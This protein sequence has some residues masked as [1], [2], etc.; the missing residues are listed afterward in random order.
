MSCPQPLL[1]FLFLSHF[2]LSAKAFTIIPHEPTTGLRL[3][4]MFIS[5]SNANDSESMEAIRSLVDF[6]DGSWKGKGTSFSV[7]ADTA[8]GIVNKKVLPNYKTSIKLGL[9]ENGMTMTETF[10]FNDTIC[11]EMCH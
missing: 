5:D 2:F 4:I 6:H 3:N 10:D 7:T 1:L 9:G 8:A 11:P